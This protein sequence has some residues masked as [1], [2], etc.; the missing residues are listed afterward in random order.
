MTSIATTS[1]RSDAR[2]VGGEAEVVDQRQ[3]A[4][5]ARDVRL[6]VGQ[7]VEVVGV[8]AGHDP[9]GRGHGFSSGE[10]APEATEREGGDA[11][12]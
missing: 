6:E 3:A 11:G 9:E 4:E 7:E 12:A 5:L 2:C 8:G 10:R 1:A